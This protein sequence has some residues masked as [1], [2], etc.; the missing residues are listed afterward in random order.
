MVG[1]VQP[2]CRMACKGSGVQIPSAPHLEIP[3]SCRGF[4][5][6]SCRSNPLARFRVRGESGPSGAEDFCRS[7]PT[8]RCPWAGGADR[9]VSESPGET[10]GSSPAG[11]RRATVRAAEIVAAYDPAT[12][13]RGC[14][15]GLHQA[16]RPARA[17]PG[18]VAQSPSEGDVWG[19]R[20]PRPGPPSAPLLCQDRGED[21]NEVTGR[22]TAPMDDATSARLRTSPKHPRPGSATVPGGYESPTTW[23]S[24][25]G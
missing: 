7:R 8:N 24:K 20:G 4:R 1:G 3:C 11:M 15:H 12:G 25:G 17:A 16:T 10:R 21:T 5:R 9:R 14:A 19:R 2:L 18:E 6:V 22:R 13:R 23:P